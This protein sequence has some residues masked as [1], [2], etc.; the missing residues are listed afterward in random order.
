[1]RGGSG[2]AAKAGDGFLEMFAGGSGGL[3]ERF[4]GGNGESTELLRE[5]A[6]ESFGT[7][8]V[9]KKNCGGVILAEVG[10]LL[11]AT[12]ACRVHIIIIALMVKNRRVLLVK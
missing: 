1:M 8:L 12:V 6:G 5:A 7:L 4:L 10:R 2:A 11:G 3:F 9:G